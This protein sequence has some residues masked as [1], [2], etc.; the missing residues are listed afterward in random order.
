MQAIAALHAQLSAATEQL[1]FA[2]ARLEFLRND[3][4]V[5]EETKNLQWEELNRLTEL[6]SA[7]AD[8][9]TT[10]AQLL[11]EQEAETAAL[12]ARFHL[13]QL[14]LEAVPLAFQ[15][16]ATKFVDVSQRYTLEIDAMMS[17]A[18][19]EDFWRNQIAATT[20]DIGLLRRQ[21]KDTVARQQMARQREE[22]ALKAEAEEEE[23][24]LSM[25][26]A[27]LTV[28]EKKLQSMPMPRE[29]PTM[30]SSSSS[31]AAAAM[32]PCH[33]RT[34]PTSSIYQTAAKPSETTLPHHPSRPT[35]SRPYEESLGLGS[36]HPHTL[37]NGQ[38]M[39]P[40]DPSFPPP[41][42]GGLQHTT[43]T[44][45]VTHRVIEEVEVVDTP[46]AVGSSGYGSSGY[47]PAP[48]SFQHHH[49]HR[50]HDSRNDNHPPQQ[51]HHHQHQHQHQQQL[52]QHPHPHGDSYEV[53][54]RPWYQGN[55]HNTPS[56]CTYPLNLT[57]TITLHTLIYSYTCT[58]TITQS[59]DLCL[60]Q[61]NICNI[62]MFVVT[63]HP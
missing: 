27:C 28:Y 43:H 29:S 56:R 32:P 7:T 12:E 33:S 55:A 20:R 19:K 31:S 11:A 46:V 57:F 52:Q 59:L 17:L 49:H 44:T 39:P 23:N 4:K 61:Y 13:R 62:G 53:A 22:M 18:I 30:Q 15:K 60:L 1:D 2:N 5:V 50:Y 6:L 58:I 41:G 21:H 38:A 10:D 40:A 16:L 45:L 14:Q 48:S 24:S 54:E 9:E 37:G 34:T 63:R 36:S 42:S 8:D 3:N 35:K 47:P 51:Q 25:I 26:E